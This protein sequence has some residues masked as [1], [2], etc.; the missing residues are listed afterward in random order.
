L[1]YKVTDFHSLEWS[2]LDGNMIDG[3]IKFE[4]MPDYVPYT[5][6]RFE[7]PQLF[8]ECVD[9]KYGEIAPVSD[10]RL[11]IIKNNRH[12]VILESPSIELKE[13]F[14]FID[15]SNKEANTGSN[16]GFVMHEGTLL[17]LASDRALL[18][19]RESGKI[20]M[21]QHIGAIAKIEQG[22]YVSLAFKIKI[23]SEFKIIDAVDLEKLE[24][25]K[26]IRNIAAHTFKFD[27]SSTELV[28]CLNKLF[29]ANQ[30]EN[31]YVFEKVCS[32]LPLLL[33]HAYGVPCYQLRDKLLTYSY[34]R[35][36]LD[37]LNGK[38]DKAAQD[39]TT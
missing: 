3:K 12:E 6:S 7:K 22:E 20:K 30:L 8:K 16:R 21:K 1:N 15:S 24:L 33:S 38:T 4:H 9:G 2:D 11:S 18:K 35:N 23:L 14:D 26:S 31:T 39:E 29:Y 32:D 5:L 19:L 17:E 28:D 10:H 34:G 37:E 13:T 36:I 27:L 25:I